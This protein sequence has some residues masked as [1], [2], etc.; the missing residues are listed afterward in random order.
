MVA[1]RLKCSRQGL[2]IHEHR[3]GE[4]QP[5]VDERECTGGQCRSSGSCMGEDG[6]QSRTTVYCL[7]TEPCV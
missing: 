1:W 5:F 4:T 2:P 7:K 3:S 6:Q